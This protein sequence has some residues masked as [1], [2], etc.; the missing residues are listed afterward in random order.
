MFQKI[1]SVVQNFVKQIS[2]VIRYKT[3]DEKDISRYCDN[4]L[5]ELIESDVAYDIAERIVTD[6]GNRLREIKIPRGTNVEDYINS[7]VVDVLRKLLNNA[8]SYDFI[9]YI[10]KSSERPIKIVFMGIN[11][12]GK[13]TTIAK[14]AYMLKKVGIKPVIVAA[15]TFR[16]GA[17]EQLK[18][19]SENLG[20]PFIGGKYGADPAAIAFNGIVFASK[21]KFDVVL[22]DTAGRMHIDVD[23]MNELKKV[24]RVVNPHIKVLVLDALTGN[25]AIEQAKKF[26]E[27]IGIDG[28]ILTKLDADAN[29][30]AAVSVVAG[31]GKKIFYVGIGQRYDD[32]IRYSPDIIIRLLF[33][34]SR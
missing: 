33:K 12:V 16:A 17:Q 24:I 32:L 1:R 8:T 9:E 30:G 27:A 31:L 18:K 21:N 26:D 22:I 6:I 14:V 25:D 11:G 23:L 5:N 15:D 28:V 4:L 19:H 13:T 7:I 10:T 3:L 2:D 34:Q 29:G 20:I